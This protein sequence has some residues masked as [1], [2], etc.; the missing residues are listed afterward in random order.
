MVL[1]VLKLFVCSHPLEL[2]RCPMYLCFA[3]PWEISW[4]PLC[5]VFSMLKT[6]KY[7]SMHCYSW[8]FVCV[9]FHVVTWLLS[10]IVKII[11]LMP[12]FTVLWS[13]LAM[14]YIDLIKIV[15]AL[16]HLK[17]YYFV[18]TY[19]LED[20][21]ELSLGM[22]ICCK[23]IYNFFMLHACFIPIALCFVYTSWHFYAFS[24]TNLL[25]RCHSASSCFL[26]VLCFGKVTQEILSELDKTKVEV[27]ILLT[28]RR[29]PKGRQRAARRRL[30]HRV[31]RVIPW[32]H[33]QV[34]W[35]P[36]APSDI[37]LPPINSLHRENPKGL[38]IYPRKVL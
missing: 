9:T 8:S 14:L 18:I 28:R 35:A 1:L 23:R 3:S 31:A 12:M 26:L 10:S 5:Y 11:S 2:W 20:K 21:Q 24:G 15:L 33:H 7:L 13:Q 17:N 30:H 38:N 34:V 27:P 25:T 19:L 37:T 29:S 16:C 32:P 22:M 6:N 36:Q 4:I